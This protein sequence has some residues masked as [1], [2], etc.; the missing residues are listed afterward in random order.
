MEYKAFI[1]DLDGVIVS[2]DEYHFIAWK[3]IASREGIPF[4]RETNNSLRGI[5]R[6]ASL[7]IILN[8]ADKTYSEEKKQ[9]LALN[10]NAIYQLL[11]Q[12]LGPED[13]LP[14]VMEVLKHLRLAGY[15]LAVG[16]SSRNTK[17]ILA[18]LGLNDYFE[19]VA[20]GTEIRHSKPD[21]EVFLKAAE[22]LGI[23]PEKCVVIEDATAGIEA[24][25]RGGMLA[26]AINDAT[27]SPLADIRINSMAEIIDLFP[28]INR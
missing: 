10:K 7:D 14:G 8:K 22:K 16:S 24:A 13:L 26:I 9:E 28:A 11:L 12:N 2:T 23:E 19:A 27:K 6:M 20:D 4:D 25:K 1:F 5:S 17:M 18:R 3:E 15:L 21:P